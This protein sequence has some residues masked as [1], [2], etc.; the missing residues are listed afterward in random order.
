MTDDGVEDQTIDEG[1]EAEESQAESGGGKVPVAQMMTI[2]SI[3][4]L[5]FIKSK[6]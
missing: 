1:W 2:V 4:S 6:D 3:L 5:M